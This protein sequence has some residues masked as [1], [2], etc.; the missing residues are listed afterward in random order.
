[1]FY[2]RGTVL[3]TGDEQNMKMPTPLVHVISRVWMG[4]IQEIKK[5]EQGISLQIG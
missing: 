5:N 3:D 4:A 2:L 1:M